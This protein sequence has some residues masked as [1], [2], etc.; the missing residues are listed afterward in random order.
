MYMSRLAAV[1]EHAFMKALYDAGFPVP[2]PVDQN[3]H[4]VLMTLAK[5]FP[6]YQLNECDRLDEVGV[7]PRCDAAVRQDDGDGGAAGAS[8]PD[9]RRLQRVQPDSGPRALRV[10]AD[11]L[12]AD[13]EHFPRERRRLLRPR[14]RVRGALLPPPLQLRARG[15]GGGGALRQQVPRLSDV[16]NEFKLDRSV[17]ASG[18]SAEDERMLLEVGEET[19]AEA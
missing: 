17:E 4:C 19:G 14:R 16:E 10:H 5:G 13:G 7:C 15:G 2:R 3:R 11:R 18:F 8:R 1:K 6:L 12:P 9:P